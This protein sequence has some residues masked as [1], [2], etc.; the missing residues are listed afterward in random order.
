MPDRL[1]DLIASP[2]LNGIDFVEITRADQ[3]GLRVHF[4]NAVAVSGT[5]PASHDHR[6]RSRRPT[7]PVLPFVAADWGVDDEGRPLLDLRTPFPGDF[8]F[9]R[10]AIASPVLDSYFAS[11]RFSF[12]AGCPSDLDCAPPAGLR[13]GAGRRPGHRLP[14]QGLHQLQARRCSTT[15]PRPTRSGSSADEPDLGVMLRGAAQRGGR[16]PELPAGPDRRRGHAGDRDAARLGRARRRGSS[17]TSRGRPP[18]RARSSSSTWRPRSLPQGVVVEAAQPD[19]GALAFELGDGLVD[20]DTGELV[21]GTLLVDPRWNRGITPHIWDDSQ[22]CLPVGATEMWVDGHGF[23]FPVGDPQ[24][25][26][27]GI[28]LLIDTQRRQRGRPAGARDR[29]PDRSG[30][31]DRQPLRRGRHP[32]ELGRHRGAD[33]RARADP[34]GARRQ[35]RP[36]RRGSPLHRDLRDRPGR[37]SARTRRSRRSRAAGRTPDAATPSRC[38]CTRC[39]RAGSRGSRGRTARRPPSSPSSSNR[40]TPATCRGRGAGAARCSTPTCSRLRTPS[41]R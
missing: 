7:V 40:P 6:W 8:S 36:R 1:A 25:G 35:P 9:Y 11:A 14:G 34:D 20:P 23:A 10:L 41:I 15:P 17:T 26:T 19:G 31:G 3:T 5:S 38:T 28:A 13:R 30:R 29:A 2:T 33:R 39:A 4:L 21:T 18:R 32:P 27:T 37:R 22:V 24:L 16:R 12:K